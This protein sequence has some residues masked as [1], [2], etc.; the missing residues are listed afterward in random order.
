MKIAYPKSEPAAF[1]EAA[2]Q[3]IFLKKHLK[4]F[5]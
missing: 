5:S 2:L 1:W 3:F 4:S